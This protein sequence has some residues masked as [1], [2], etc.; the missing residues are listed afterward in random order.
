MT[1]PLLAFGAGVLTV[2]APCVLPML[3]IVLGASIGRQNPSRPIFVALGFGLTF[4]AVALV[5]SAFTSILGLSPDALRQGAAVLLL[6]FGVLMVWPTP[7][8][9]LAVHAGGWLGRLAYAPK[10]SADGPL[11][12]LVLGASLGAVW[13]PCAGP[14]LASILTL[15]AT[16]PLGINTAWLILSYALGASV[17][18]LAISYGGQYAT[19]RVRQIAR[20]AHRMQQVFGVLVVLVALAMLFKVDGLATGWLVQ[21]FETLFFLD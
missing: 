21:A 4:A 16:E 20:H 3:P 17:P 14:V 9:L 5:F 8:Q 13:T 11:G 19:T 6:I 12:G 7:F 1:S 18:M 15:I 10:S 2:A